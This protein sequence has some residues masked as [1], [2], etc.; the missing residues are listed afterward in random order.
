VAATI[1][2]MERSS[3]D[4]IAELMARDLDPELLRRAR[5]KTPTERI[6]WLEEM[7]AFAD[8]ARKARTD[9][10]ERAPRPAR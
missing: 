2:S 6:I 7:Q 4:V 3:F 1:S 9:A 5:D 8:D 10:A